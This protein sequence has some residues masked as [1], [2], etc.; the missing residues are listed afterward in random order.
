[1]ISIGQV[2]LQGQAVPIVAA[3]VAL[4]GMAPIRR[5]TVVVSGGGFIEHVR[6]PID[7]MRAKQLAED[8]LI[9]LVIASALP[10]LH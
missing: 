1:M 3:N 5:V 8:E 10:L 4:A 9:V 2:A 7:P 6:L